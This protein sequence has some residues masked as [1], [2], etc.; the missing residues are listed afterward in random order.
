MLSIHLFSVCS[1][2]I[3]R[4]MQSWHF[5]WLFI[6]LALVPRVAAQSEEGPFPNI[7]FRLFNQFIKDNFSSKVT[8]SQVLLVLFTLTDNTDLLRLHA[9]QQNPEH[10][11]ENRSPDSGGIRGLACALQDK[12]GDGQRRLLKDA[13]SNNSDDQI[14]AIG[15][16][17]DGLAKVLKLYPYNKHGQFQGKL[18]PISHASIQASQLICPNAVVCESST[19]NPCSLLQSTKIQSIPRVTLIKGSTIYENVHVLTGRCP[20]CRTIYLADR[21]CVAQPDNKFT[22]V[23]LNSPRYLKV[24]QSLWV[25]HLFSNA[26]L[27]SMYSFHASAASYTEFWNNSFWSHHQGNCSKLSHRHFGKPLFKNPSAPLL[28]S[29]TSIWNFRMVLPLMMQQD[30][31]LISWVKMELSV[32]QTNTLARNVLNLTKE[33]QI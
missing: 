25:D 26:V 23:Y 31:H 24:G 12:I 22:R 1:A 5:T 16:K 7:P 28:L 8:L 21:E 6:L 29:Q 33:L 20:K 9:R 30:K 18:K 11:D 17:L 19:C 14:T 15:E 3:L 13:D 4:I 27:N 2:M 32:L 10:P